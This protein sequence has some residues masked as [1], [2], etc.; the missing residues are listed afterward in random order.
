MSVDARYFEIFYQRSDPWGYRTRWYEQRKRALLLAA[1]H[2]LHYRRG[3]ELG[4][5][6]GETT[7]AL[8]PRCAELVAT[9]ANAIAVEHARRRMNGTSDVRVLCMRHPQQWPSSRF[10]LVVFSELGYYLDADDFD[11]TM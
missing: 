2:R 4:C 9:D 8:A 10:D 1:L 3:L 7:A 11:A 6:I 5:S